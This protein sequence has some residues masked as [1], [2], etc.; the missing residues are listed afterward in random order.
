MSFI[1]F[2]ENRKMKHVEIILSR[3]EGVKKSDG[4]DESNEGTSIL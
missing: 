1:H 3:A 2:Y 4:R